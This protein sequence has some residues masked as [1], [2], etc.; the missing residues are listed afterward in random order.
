MFAL[1]VQGQ[2]ESGVSMITRSL[3]RVRHRDCIG[4][5]RGRLGNLRNQSHVDLPLAVISDIKLYKLRPLQHL[6]TTIA[7][8]KDNPEPRRGEGICAMRGNCGRVTMFGQDLPCVD[9]RD[10]TEVSL[11]YHLH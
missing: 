11:L 7:M 1:D 5:P 8:P 6:S 2:K 4:R 9:D 3:G 10:A